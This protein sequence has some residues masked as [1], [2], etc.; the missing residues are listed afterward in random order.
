LPRCSTEGSGRPCELGSSRF[1]LLGAPIDPLT[2][3]ETVD[4]IEQVIDAG[5][6]VQHASVNA[7]KVVRLQDDPAL[8]EALWSCEFVTADGAAVVWA[9]RLLGRPLAERVAG[10]DLME[11][12]LERAAGRGYGVYL[13]G[14]RAEVVAKAAEEMR[15]RH[16]TIQIAG[17]H[18]GYFAPAEEDEVVAAIA[19]ARPQLLFVALETPQKELF[20][21]RHRGVLRIPFAMGVGGAFDILAGR[22]RRAPSWAQRLGLEWLFRLLQEPRRLWRRYL[23][24]NTRFITLVAK[25]LARKRLARGPSPSESG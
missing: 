6:S 16:P 24:G 3:R 20:L 5:R 18:H 7:A 22:R 19:A 17:S 9:A 15:R 23:Y 1:E 4:A 10:I 13:L 12:L 8:R 14:A 2:L 11:A 21:E 25:E